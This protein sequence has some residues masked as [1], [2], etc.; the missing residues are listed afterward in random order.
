MGADAESMLSWLDSE[1]RNLIDRRDQAAGSSLAGSAL[2][3]ELALAMFGYHESRSRWVEMRE[4]SVGSVELAEKLDLRLMAA[5]LEHDRAIPEVENGSLDAAAAHL[6][7]ALETFRALP[8]RLGQARSC[9]SATHVLGRLNRVPEALEL[10]I[11]ALRLSQEQGDKTIER[12][13]YIAL[14]GLYDRNGDFALADEAF[15]RGIALAAIVGDARSLGKRYLNTGFSHLLV[16]RLDDAVEPLLQSIEI[17]RRAKNNDLQSQGLQCLAAVF[18]SRGEYEKAHQRIEEGIGLIRPLGNRLR[19]GCFIL[20]HGKFSAA[21]GD[22][23]AAIQFLEAAIA[24]LHNISPHFEAAAEELLE[25]VR[26][27]DHY[28]Y[29]FDDSQVR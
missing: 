23:P 12:V 26:R 10:G 14:G 15:E 25:L 13:S 28:T 5:W 11:E 3:P 7:T 22:F 20:E 2:L 16:G 1:Q 24:V 8:D 9:T 19:E 27:G 29:S 6:L 21:A 18:A 17:G 4:L